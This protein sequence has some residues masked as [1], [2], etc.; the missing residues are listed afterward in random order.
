MRS[1]YEKRGVFV[2]VC[3][4]NWMLAK[5]NPLQALHFA[6]GWG[7]QVSRLSAHE[8]VKFVRP[9]HRPPLPGEAE[10]TPAATVRP[11]GVKSMK[12]SGDT[13]WNRTRYLPVYSAV[14]QPPR[15][16]KWMEVNHAQPELE[17]QHLDSDMSNKSTDCKARVM[18]SQST[19][20]L[21]DNGRLSSQK[22]H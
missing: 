22:K 6:Q 11:E 17:S 14:P 1:L 10:S 21:D 19:C 7:S 20:L 4:Y 2:S 5:C 12:N 8:H 3:E 15:T 16:P 13:D 18:L 9:R